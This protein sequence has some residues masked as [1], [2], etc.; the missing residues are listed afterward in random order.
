MDDGID[1]VLSIPF[2][3]EISGFQRRVVAVF[4]LLSF[5]QRCLVDV[6]RRFEQK[7][8]QH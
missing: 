8:C 6:Y 1:G 3:C 4:A 5:M 7:G 2:L